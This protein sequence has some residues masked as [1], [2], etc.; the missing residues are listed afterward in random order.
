MELFSKSEFRERRKKL[1]KKLSSGDIVIVKSA[2]ARYKSG[3]VEYLYKQDSNFYYLTGVNEENCTF[4]MAKIGKKKYEALFI[5]ENNPKIET[6]TGRRLSADEVKDINGMDSVFYND[7]YEDYMNSLLTNG[8]TLYYSY[9]QAGMNSPLDE[10][11]SRIESLRKHFPNLTYIKNANQLIFPLRTIKSS[12]E[13]KAMEKAIEYTGMGVLNVLKKTKPGMSEYQL[14][15]EIEYEFL[16]NG[17]RQPGF[18]TIVASGKNAAVLHYISMKDIVKKNDLILIDI[19]ADCCNYSADI[20]RTFPASGKFTG[21]KKDLYAALLDI[22]KTLIQYVKPGRSMKDVDKKTIKLISKMLK[23]FKYIKDESEY[24]KYYPHSVGHMLGLDTHDVQGIQRK[25]P[26][27]KEGMV[28][29]IEPG[30]YIKED[31]I[32][33]RIEDDI[34]VTKKGRRNLSREI[35]KEIDAIEEIMEG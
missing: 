9:R 31:S 8:E 19:G 17:S 26:V 16:R 1:Y 7:K 29:T 24:F 15:A 33:I 28:V 23:S 13:I 30:V 32:G 2:P 12:A 22:Q 20:S 21:K 3:T 35:P 27:L 34:L 10:D 25:K 4:I 6:W 18:N 11:M 14:R 5:E